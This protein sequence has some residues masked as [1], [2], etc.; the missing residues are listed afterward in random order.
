MSKD[1]RGAKGGE[2]IN[3]TKHDCYSIL[4]FL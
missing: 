2:V 4:L 3:I 1:F